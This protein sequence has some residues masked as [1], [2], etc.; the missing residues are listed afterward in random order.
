MTQS[1]SNEDRPSDPFQQMGGTPDRGASDDPFGEEDD[2]FASAK[3]QASFALNVAR[4]WVKDHQKASMLGAF[5]T[6]VVLG[7]L[8]RD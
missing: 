1:P 5:A 3:L 7:A 8:V 6:G 4:T 2:P